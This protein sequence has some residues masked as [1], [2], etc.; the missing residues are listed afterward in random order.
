[1]DRYSLAQARGRLLAPAVILIALGV[2][3][4]VLLL[5]GLA[6]EAWLILSSAASGTA[7]ARGHSFGAAD[8]IRILW[9]VL[10]LIAN[11]VIVVGAVQMIRIRSHG[12]SQLACILAVVPLLSPCFIAG[13]P[14]GIWGLVALKDPDVREAFDNSWSA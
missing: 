9:T 11:A 10:M 1:V 12:L 2:I 4:I 8:A 14:F 6:L 3:S 7:P 5:L 13:I